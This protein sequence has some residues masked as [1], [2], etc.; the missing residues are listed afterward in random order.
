MFTNHSLPFAAT[1]QQ[2]RVRVVPLEDRR[3]TIRA[4]MSLRRRPHD[5]R[6]RG[7]VQP[8]QLAIRNT[9]RRS[10]RERRPVCE[11]ERSSRMPR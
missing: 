4:P 3:R 11:V 5:Q 2:R 7:Q 10:V 1:D 8:V 6:H 9:V